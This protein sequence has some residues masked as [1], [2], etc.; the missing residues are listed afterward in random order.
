MW[1]LLTLYQALRAVMVQAA[2]SQPG[3]A[4]D[5]CSFAIALQSRTRPIINL[6]YVLAS[7]RRLATSSTRTTVVLTIRSLQTPGV[8]SGGTRIVS[9]TPVCAS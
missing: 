1:A 8:L 4:P 2:E 6:T 7:S 9:T 3:I 5:R